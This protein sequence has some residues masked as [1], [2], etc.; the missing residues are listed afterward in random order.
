M[1]HAGRARTAAYKIILFTLIAMLVLWGFMAAGTVL[2][3]LATVIAPFLIFI[4][5]AF[6]LFTLY[7]FRDPTPRPPEGENLI[8][9]PAHGKVDVI[10]TVAEPQFMGGEC[11]RISVFL[12]VIDVHVQNA[13]VT[14]RVLFMKYTRGEFMNAIRTE[15]AAHNENVLLGFG[16][17]EPKGLRM[18]V[19]LIAG[20]IAR[21]IV[22]Y[23]KE[24]DEVRKGDRLSLIQFGS[25]ADIYLPMNTNIKVKLG[26]KVVGGVSVIAALE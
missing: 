26:D 15:C 17:T 4:W 18:A 6:S 23:V 9:S 14:G 24:G 2:A 7:F 19:R 21:R 8:L 13:P 16:A 12:S 1:K 11:R 22:P 10:D 5:I 3:F 25:R 20:V